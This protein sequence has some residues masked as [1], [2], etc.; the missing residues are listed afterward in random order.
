MTEL[1]LLLPHNRTIADDSAAQANMRQLIQLRW[2]AAAGQLVTILIVSHGLN[3]ALPLTPMLGI[4][5]LIAAFNLASHWAVKHRPIGNPALFAALCFDVVSL[6][7]L[8][9][10]SG[11][12]TNPFAPLFLLQLVLAALLLEAW[13]AWALVV[14]AGF[15]FSL[16]TVVYRPLDFTGYTPATVAHLVLLA[17]G[18][19]IVLIAT[20]L[21]FFI[22]R[23]GRIL[24]ARD[25]YV[26]E[27]QRRAAQE[28]GIVRMGLLASSAAHELGTPLASLDVIL[29]DWRRVPKLAN[30][31]VLADE[32]TEMQQ[33]V[34]R[35]KT[36]VTDVL[37]AAGEPRGEAPEAVASRTFLQEVADE[38]RAAHP[39]EP[40]FL[41]LRL[42]DEPIVA[43]PSLRQ[44]IWNLLENARE[45]SPMSV[46]L[47]AKRDEGSLRI[48][49]TDRGEG[50]SSEV[51]AHIGEPHV[52]AKGPGH[53]VGLF[54]TTNIVRKLGGRL[55]AMNRVGA[56]GAIVVLTLPIT[57]IGAT[58]AAKRWTRTVRSLS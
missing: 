49:V 57:T 11:G 55:D 45:A 27:L 16:L 23:V 7:V 44:A 32:M 56:P 3:L 35:C 31:P 37:Q 53:G 50:F 29:S 2:I 9:Y 36:I 25:A 51:L 58:E 28:D 18:V 14:L 42:D 20:L 38:W 39:A 13:S 19:C 1:P 33:A 12:A 47:S 8:L 43:D 5:A 21:V 24:R 10:F 15:C 26:A 41:D 52:S 40:L 17:Q 6:S 54:L 34:A 46:G 4:V 30:D 48:E 22:G